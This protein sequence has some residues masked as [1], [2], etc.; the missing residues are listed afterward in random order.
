MAT[1]GGVWI[2]SVL[3]VYLT[4]SRSLLGL[5]S[6]SGIVSVQKKRRKEVI[7]RLDSCLLSSYRISTITLR[8]LFIFNPLVI[9]FLFVVANVGTFSIAFLAEKLLKTV[10]GGP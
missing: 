4:L 10:S 6:A 8:M 3:E 2:A 7:R 5:T 9:L 1:W